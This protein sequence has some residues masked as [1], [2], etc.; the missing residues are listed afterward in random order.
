[1]EGPPDDRC[2]AGNWRNFRNC[3]LL[4][5]VDASSSSQ[6]TRSVAHD[7]NN[8]I[9]IVLLNAQLVLDQLLPD[10]PLR[11]ELVELCAAAERASV[12][13][14]QLAPGSDAAPVMLPPARA[15]PTAAQAGTVL[16]VEDD[17]SVRAAIRSVLTRRGFRVLDAADGAE[18]DAVAQ[19]EP[20]IDLVLADFNLPDQSGDEIARSVCERH[21]EA[22]VLFMS[23]SA[24]GGHADRFLQKPFTPQ[25]LLRLVR[26]ALEAAP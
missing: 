12:L 10:H 13:A 4:P 7:L 8:A 21:A 5:S 24:Q 18:A 22:R 6:A 9:A 20:I 19:A 23:G 2:W 15:T 3:A 17:E 26:L 11:A 14:R 1:M 25:L 16:V